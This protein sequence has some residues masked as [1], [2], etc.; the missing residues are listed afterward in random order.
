MR[1]ARGGFAHDV[2]LASKL[3]RQLLS[4]LAF[5]K[6]NLAKRLMSVKWK[7]SGTDARLK[8]SIDASRTIG[9]V[10]GRSLFR[11]EASNR[12][13]AGSFLRNQSL[14]TPAGIEN[15]DHTS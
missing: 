13:I 8:G 11:N 10:P 4:D 14:H 3:D 9:P 6:R 15:E 7:L 1:A 12:T 5:L 2:G